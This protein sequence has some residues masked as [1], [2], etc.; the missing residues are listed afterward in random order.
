MIPIGDL[1]ANT[2]AAG[3]SGVGARVL[4]ALPEVPRDRP[5]VHRRPDPGHR[6]TWPGRSTSRGSGGPSAT[7]TP[8]PRRWAT[9]SSSGSSSTTTWR[10]WTPASL[11]SPA[12]CWTGCRR[13]AGSRRA[14]AV[15]AAAARA[16]QQRPAGQEH[17]GRRPDPAHRLRLQRHERP[18]VRR[19]RPGHGGR[20]RPGP[21]RRSR[22][23]PTSARTT[24]CSTHGPGCSASPPSTP[25]RCCSSGWTR[26]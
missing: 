3:E 11:A 13:C 4:Q 5:G 9:R 16:Q 14:L 12:G 6:P 15:N 10:C 17:H 18:D 22:A 23:R 2:V 25:G 26:C 1:I 21:D 8:R 7:C 20:L 24:R 19:R